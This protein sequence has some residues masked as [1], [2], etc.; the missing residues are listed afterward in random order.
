MIF[1]SCRFSSRVPLTL[2]SQLSLLPV[3]FDEDF[4]YRV[5]FYVRL[6]PTYSL[7]CVYTLKIHGDCM[8]I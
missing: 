6:F 4:S 2:L 3:F 5:M 8:K 7:I 1:F